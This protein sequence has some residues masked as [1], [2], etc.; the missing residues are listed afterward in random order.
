MMRIGNR[1]TERDIRDDLIRLGYRGKTA[2][3]E[4][5]E[6]AAIERPGWIQVFRFEVHVFDEDDNRHH[7]YGVVRDDERNRTEIRYF[8]APHAQRQQIETWSGNM[9][10]R[11]YR[12]RTR[13][14]K[15]LL[16]VFV[17]LVVVLAAFTVLVKGL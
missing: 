14:E 6:L 4:E 3:F 10:R 2:K 5:L 8:D 12:P 13:A 17:S 9:I 11:E 16:G 15:I 1:V 7:L